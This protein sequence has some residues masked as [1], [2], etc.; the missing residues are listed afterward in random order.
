MCKDDWVKGLLIA[1]TVALIG[2]L[3]FVVIAAGL[4]A[5]V[6][7]APGS[8][9]AMW[10]A[11][12]FTVAGIACLVGLGFAIKDYYACMG[13][14]ERCLPPL[15]SFQAAI[16]GMMAVLVIQALACAAVA[17]IAWIP[18]LGLPGMAYIWG[19]L[20]LQLFLVPTLWHFW[21]KIQE[22]LGPPR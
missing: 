19:A 6:L 5:S 18:L 17:G 20:F 11:F 13:G 21:K 2:A 4:N 9:G 7:G 16:A 10:T 3:T 22:C 15:G 14:G 8:P 1:L 12:G